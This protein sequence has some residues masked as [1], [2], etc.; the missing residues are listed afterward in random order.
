VVRGIE[1]RRWVSGEREEDFVE[2]CRGADRSLGARNRFFRAASRSKKTMIKLKSSKRHIERVA[3][4]AL[5]N[6]EGMSGL[7]LST[8]ARASGKLMR[9]A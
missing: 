2:H 7:G 3:L 1:Q 4:R 9:R 5:L 8:S 6:V